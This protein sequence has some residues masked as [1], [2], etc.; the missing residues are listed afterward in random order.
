MKSI[1]NTIFIAFA[2]WLTLNWIA[3]NP[4]KVEAVRTDVNHV[5][6]DG[7]DAASASAK[8]SFNENR[9]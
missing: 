3:D 4:L 5:L 7:Y 1:F 2:G 6:S 8:K 9:Q